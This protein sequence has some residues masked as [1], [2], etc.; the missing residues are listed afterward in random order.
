MITLQEII[1]SLAN[2][3]KED[4][5]FLF[6]TLR[7]RREKETKQVRVHSLR[8][9]YSNLATNSDDFADKKQ[10]EIALEN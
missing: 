5:D 4:Q 3:S 10:A 8:G 9:K 6:E 7:K 1:N 2:L